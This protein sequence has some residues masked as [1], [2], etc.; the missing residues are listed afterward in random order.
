MRFGAASDA[1]IPTSQVSRQGI[2]SGRMNHDPPRFTKLTA[3][4]RQYAF[5][6]VDV[7]QL[8]VERFAGPHPR[9]AQKAY[10]RVVGP[11][12]QAGWGIQIECRREDLLYFL[13]GIKIG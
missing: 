4:N 7:L 3:A 5:L 8:E 1:A 12:A 9:G 11:S 10:Q 13:V 6:Q 2:A